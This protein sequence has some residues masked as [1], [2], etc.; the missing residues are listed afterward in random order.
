MG[1][2]ILQKLFLMRHF[3]YI[4]S[5]QSCELFLMELLDKLISAI[6]LPPDTV[7]L[8]MSKLLNY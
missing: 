3:L 4:I 6:S 8:M 5:G 1:E 7:L 2:S